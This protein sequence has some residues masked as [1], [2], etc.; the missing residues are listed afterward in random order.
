[1]SWS[2]G[3]DSERN[4]DIGYGVPAYCEHPRCNER[5]DRGLSYVCGGEP[6]GGEHGCG[7]FFC[8]NHLRYRQPRGEDRVYQNCF[9]CATY[10]LPYRV[11]PEHPEWIEWK[12][13][14]ASWSDWRDANPDEVARLVAL[15]EGETGR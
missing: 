13:S 5:I 10:K 15:L 12:L 8:G 4:R 9:R 2:L 11:K 6:Y 14:D 7:M 3:F 1:M